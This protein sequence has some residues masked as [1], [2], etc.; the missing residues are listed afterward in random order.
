MK[1]QFTH[2]AYQTAAVFRDASFANDSSSVTKI[3]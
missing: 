2:K 1:L 3:D